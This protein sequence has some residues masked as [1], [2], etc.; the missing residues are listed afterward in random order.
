M[1]QIVYFERQPTPG[2]RSVERVFEAVRGALPSGLQVNVVRCPTP[3]H[4]SWWLLQGVALARAKKGEVNHIVGDV[5][6]TALGLPGSTCILTIHDLNYLDQLKGLRGALYRWLYFRIPL[7]RCAVIT[8]ISEKTRDRIAEVFPFAADRIVVIPD[9]V[10]EGYVSRPKLFNANY[11]R[12]L[13][14]GTAPHK[15]VGRLI[16]AIRRLPCKLHVIGRL[17]D[18]QMRLIERSQV[19]CQNSENISDAEM[20]QAYDQSDMVVFVSLAE[21]FGMPIIE[22]QAIGR[23]VITSNLSPMKEVAGVGALTVDPYDVSAIRNAIRHIVEDGTARQRV[24]AAGR[25]NAKRFSAKAV[26]EQYT[27]LY[28]RVACYT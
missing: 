2:H 19:D 11:P 25:D 12:I 3:Y 7:R 16:Q 27:R 15:N 1:I 26:A 24:I 21:G 20:L 9:P 14:V 13:Q 28:Q 4:S 8:A 23:P 5:H 6:Y 17:D 10:P 22:A 18:E